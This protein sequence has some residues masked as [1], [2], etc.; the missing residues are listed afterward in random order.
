MADISDFTPVVQETIETIRAR[1]DADVNAG[2]DPAD[3]RWV[4]TV[5]GGP[6]WDL[7]QTAGLEI[8]RLWDALGT[9][10]PAAMFPSFA[11]GNFI[12][13]HAE[14]YGL[15]RK[16]SIA[17]TG[18][19]RFTGVVG[20]PIAT[21]TQVGT[22]PSDP[23]D[24][25]IVY[26]TT[27]SGVIPGGGYIDLPVQAA[28]EGTDGNV[29]V[30]VVSLLLSPIGGISAVSNVTAMSSGE[31]TESD[32]DLQNRV[33]IEIASTVGSGTVS[34]YTRWALAFEG[35]GNVT[36]Q[37]LWA[38][39]GTVRVVVTDTNNQPVSNAVVAG[40]QAELDPVGNA[41]MGQGLAPIGAVVTVSTPTF[42]YANA[43]ATIVHQ[44]GYSLDGAGGTIATRASIVAAITAYVDALT[45]GSAVVL[46]RIVYEALTVPGVVDV[47]SPQLA[48][49]LTSAA[50]LAGTPTDRALSG[51]NLPV[52]SGSV[53]NIVL[54]TLS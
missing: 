15:V 29:A 4:D 31:D 45:P 48:G 34:D 50:A 8:E 42:Y 11:W 3:P 1:M 47:T 35:V 22:A 54:V 7:S 14:T 44:T 37:P 27:A 43:Q 41:G 49:F 39:A 53:P 32:T 23:D 40:L 9:E 24:D 2:L 30:G 10:I 25:S 6:Y 51:T 33:L 5:E 20:S 38:G 17:A 13:D 12:D 36:V 26:A 46:N 19:V 16:P 28:L 52:P 18:T 21:G